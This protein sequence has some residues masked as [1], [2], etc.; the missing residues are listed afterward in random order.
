VI[1]SKV[2]SKNYVRKLRGNLKRIHQGVREHLKIKSSK[3]KEWYDK[4]ARQISFQEGQK[5][6]FFNP[7]RGKG[8]APEL[9]KNWEGGSC[10]HPRLPYLVVKK[11]S[12]VVFCIQKTPRHR[13]KI[14]HSDRLAPYRERSL[15]F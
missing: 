8:K 10:K 12:E 6:W 2:Q 11:L 13:K 7:Q 1:E 15:S 3:I 14:I 9:Q 5:V 4:G